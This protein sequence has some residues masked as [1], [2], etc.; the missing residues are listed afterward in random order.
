MLRGTCVS[1]PIIRGPQNSWEH[2]GWVQK[3]KASRPF[4]LSE[5]PFQAGLAILVCYEGSAHLS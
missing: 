1:V 2:P 4:S 3:S 5:V